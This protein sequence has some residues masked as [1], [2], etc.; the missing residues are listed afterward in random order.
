MRGLMGALAAPRNELTSLDF[1]RNLGGGWRPSKSGESVTTRTA[2]Q[3]STV[4][5]CVRVLAEGV[6]QVDLNIKR[7][8]KDNAGSE[9]A[10][11]H[12]LQRV[13]SV[14]PNPWQT[15][16][17]FRETM[18]FHLTLTYNFYAFINRVLDDIVELIPFEP[19]RVTVI[20]KGNVRRYRVSFP[21]GK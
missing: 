4:L 7:R 16:F 11:D 6:S 21:D 8:L 20:R 10:E 19:E 1:L 12:A 13:L 14:Q 17:A 2:L 3:V 5:D 15:S 9:I 18:M